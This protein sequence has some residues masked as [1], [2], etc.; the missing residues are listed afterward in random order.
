MAPLAN[1]LSGIIDR[2]PDFTQYFFTLARREVKRHIDMVAIIARGQTRLGIAG[3]VL[4]KSSSQS[5]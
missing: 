2:I 4:K 5:A 3:G 1:E